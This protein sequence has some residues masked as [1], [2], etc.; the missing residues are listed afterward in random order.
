M[1]IGA[2]LERDPSFFNHADGWRHALCLNDESVRFLDTPSHFLNAPLTKIFSAT[3][4]PVK[5]AK[6]SMTHRGNRR[7]NSAASE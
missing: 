2:R 7:A 5:R 6:R 4:F 3:R 1:R